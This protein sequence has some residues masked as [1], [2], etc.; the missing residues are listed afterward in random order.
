MISIYIIIV[1][2]L[3]I[4][5]KNINLVKIAQIGKRIEDLADSH[6]LMAAKIMRISYI[7]KKIKMRIRS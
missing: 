7:L 2:S 6:K 4:L 5:E 3:I 1:I